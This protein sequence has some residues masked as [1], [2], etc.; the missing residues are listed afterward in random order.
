MKYTKKKSFY[1]IFLCSAFLFWEYSQS[2]RISVRYLDQY[3]QEHSLSLSVVDKERLMPFM[4]ILFAE[5]SF[6]YTLLGSKPL[7]WSCYRNALPF[8]NLTML[9]DSL[10]KHHRTLRLGWKT[11]SKYRHLFPAT[12]FWA[13]SPKFDSK[14][15]SI[16]IVNEEKFNH[17]V[18]KHKQDFQYVL[19][20]EVIDGFQL[21]REAKDRSLM[22]EV[23]ESHQALMGIVLGYG[24]DNSWE[25]LRRAQKRDPLCCVWDEANTKQEGIRVRLSAVNIEDC[26][27]LESCPSFAGIPDSEESLALKKEYLLTR[28]K[29]IDYYKGKDF[30]E[31]TL[32]LLAGFRPKDLN[33]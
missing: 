2:R 7:S 10:K 9:R 3:G 24:R 12:T 18:N 8:T 19:N 5:D 22:N 16:L 4:R 29:V 28:Q 23:L 1:L 11:W 32:S 27:A 26:L 25:F 6:A 31:A 20:R 33:E 14:R 13:E 17:V 21:L 15:V 30:L